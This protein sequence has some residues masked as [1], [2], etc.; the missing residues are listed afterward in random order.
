MP[1]GLKASFRKHDLSG[2]A[3]GLGRFIWHLLYPTETMSGRER[4]KGL[5]ETSVLMSITNAMGWVMVDWATPKPLV[6]FIG[7]TALI[8]TGYFVIWFYWKGQNWARILV[9]LTSL[10]CLYNLH[11]WNH[12]G[13]VVRIMVGAEAGLAIFLLYWLNTHKVRAFFTAAKS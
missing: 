10:L 7:F 4:P 5:T 9:L 13:A 3:T 2:F 8:V 1:R 6:T 11:N 12:S